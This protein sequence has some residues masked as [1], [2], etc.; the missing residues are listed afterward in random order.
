MWPPRRPCSAMPSFGRI[1]KAS[2]VGRNSRS[3]CVHQTVTEW[4]DTFN[5]FFF[6][7]LLGP[8]SKV[9]DSGPR[10]KSETQRSSTLMPLMERQFVGEIGENCG[11]LSGLAHGSEFGSSW[12][13]C[14]PPLLPICHTTRHF[15][16]H[17]QRFTACAWK[18]THVK[19]R[20]L[21]HSEM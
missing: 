21:V 11:V 2:C 20:C 4:N 12:G 19:R 3:Q 8:R 1:A 5:V 17:F 16:Q 14:A 10:L 9:R 7:R 6:D 13:C 15:E 18:N